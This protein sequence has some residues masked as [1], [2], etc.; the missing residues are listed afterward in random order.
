MPNCHNC[1]TGIDSTDK[2][3][4][5]CGTSLARSDQADQSKDSKLPPETPK[6]IPSVVE[7]KSPG[8]SLSPTEMAEFQRWQKMVKGPP[9]QQQ[10]AKKPIVAQQ[11]GELAKTTGDFFRSFREISDGVKK[12]INSALEPANKTS[13][14]RAPAVNPVSKPPEKPQLSPEE[15]IE[16]NKWR[17]L[18]KEKQ[19][20]EDNTD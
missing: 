12:D 6:E 5:N 13:S 7:Q 14:T 15:T 18:V 8:N 4:R 10:T 20:Q 11:A 2:F 3:C 1:G 19:N 9:P 17:Q 16:F